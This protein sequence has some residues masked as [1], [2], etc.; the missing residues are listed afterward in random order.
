MFDIKKDESISKTFRIPGDLLKQL[1]KLA[2]EKN[3]SLT[4]VVVQCC[5]YA[6]KNLKK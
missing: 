5:E 3:I 1:E 4:K 6:I 2:D